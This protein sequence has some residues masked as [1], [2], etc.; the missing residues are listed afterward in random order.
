MRVVLTGGAGGLGRR[1][2][3]RLLAADHGV[4]ALD[5]DEAGLAALPDE[6]DRRAVDLTDRE[7]V[8]RSLSGVEPDI[9]LSAVGWY[10]LGALEDCPPDSLREHL[11][12]NLLAVH[13]P[14]R[15]LLPALRRRSGRVG[16][17]GSMVGSV[18]LPYHG[19]YSASKA[20]L[21]A[22][23]ES[24]RRELRPRGVDVSLIEPGPVRTGFNERAT[25]ALDPS[26]DSAYAER[27]RAFESYSPEATDPEAVAD[28]MIEAA[29]GENPRARYRVSP[30]ARWL[31]RLESVLPPV[32]Y[33]RL[34]RSGLPGGLLHRLIER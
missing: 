33:D 19:A 20:G 1:A 13:T 11:E 24:L 27:Y 26:D 12:A 10:E 32:V 4:I 9:F 7:A 22:Y 15:V 31:P 29:T 2:V 18:P 23:T 17:V 14:L 8:E 5:R 21:D 3:T 34:V 16:I 30:R 6:V 25:E 28:A